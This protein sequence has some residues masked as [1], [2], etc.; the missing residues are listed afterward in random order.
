M[1]SIRHQPHD[2]AVHAFISAWRQRQLSRHRFARE[3]I[4]GDFVQFNYL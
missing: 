4:M 3:K 1:P 2:A